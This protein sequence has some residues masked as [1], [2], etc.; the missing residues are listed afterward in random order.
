MTYTYTYRRTQK[1]NK[2][3]HKHCTQDRISSNIFMRGRSYPRV[4]FVIDVSG[5]MGTPMPSMVSNGDGNAPPN[6]SLDY[7]DAEMTSETRLQFVLRQMFDILR[8]VLE[9]HQTF[10][11][12]S[13]NSEVLCNFVFVLQNYMFFYV[14]IDTHT[15]LTNTCACMQINTQNK[16][17]QNK[18][19]NKNRS[20]Y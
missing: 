14:A 2:K 1:Q 12:L 15:P 19:I 17:K 9:P 3:T 20:T 16:T 13:F 5:S 11:V 6:S 7:E 4:C 18:E 10:S 8:F